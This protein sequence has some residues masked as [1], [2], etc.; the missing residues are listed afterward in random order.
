MDLFELDDLA[1]TLQAELDEAAAEEARRKAQAWLG[2]ATRLT[3]WP[4]PIPED[5]RAWALELAAL[6]YDNPSPL[7]SER[8]GEVQT[9]P[10]WARRAEILAEARTVYGLAAVNGSPVG[11]FPAAEPWPDP[12]V[13][14]YGWA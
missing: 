14:R 5:L 13:Y 4:T 11:V 7:L 2:S 3:V 1:A 10:Y 6:A 9:A 12:V 8:V